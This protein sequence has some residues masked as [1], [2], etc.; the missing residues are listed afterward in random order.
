MFYH[1][2]ISMFP[3]WSYFFFCFLGK[4]GQ[5]FP[6][7]FKVI[8]V[9]EFSTT[10][11]SSQINIVN[12]STT[13]RVGIAWFIH[14]STTTAS[15]TY[16]PFWV[17]SS[18]I[19]VTQLQLH[20]K[21]YGVKLQ[22]T[23]IPSTPRKESLATTYLFTKRVELEA[24]PVKDKTRKSMTNSFKFIPHFDQTHISIHIYYHSLVPALFVLIYILN[25]H[26][27]LFLFRFTYHSCLFMFSS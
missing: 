26:T 12:F 20:T 16:G 23:R 18:L 1:W 2:L 21:C 10:P 24:L 8:P 19:T 5:S 4:I 27:C 17:T 7:I 14:I 13:L 6:C 11:E 22:S 25:S 9:P 3:F 15:K